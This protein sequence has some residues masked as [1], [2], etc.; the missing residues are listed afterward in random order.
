MA[1][2]IAFLKM[3]SLGNDFVIIAQDKIST[4]L[5]QQ[6]SNRRL[7]VGCDQ[8]LTVVK[9]AAAHVHGDMRIYNADGS[10]AEA[11][12]NGT[13]CVMWHLARTY[14]GP[15]VRLKTETGIL[16]G[17]VTDDHEVEVTQGMPR[18]LQEEPL[19]ISEFGFSEGWAV[20]M[21]NPH[22]VVPVDTL[23]EDKC[24]RAGARLSAH[25]FFP[26]KANVAFACVQEN[27]IKLWMFE[28]GAGPTP[29]CASGASAAVFALVQAELL[30]EGAHAVQVEN[31]VLWV[32]CHAQQPLRHRASVSYVFDGTWHVE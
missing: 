32:T 4:Q 30:S 21:G 1:E 13:R 14:G 17:R 20:S 25:P 22:L 8:V 29:A 23:D 9:S 2:P 5:V 3:H 24:C 12:G 7:G 6:L 10:E 16:D 28:R 15:T 19:D 18:L 31:G 27:S 26:E 11:C